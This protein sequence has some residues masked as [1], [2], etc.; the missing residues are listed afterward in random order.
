[1]SHLRPFELD[2]AFNGEEAREAGRGPFRRAVVR[3]PW[4]RSNPYG[5][6]DVVAG[7][8]R[9]VLAKIDMPN[10]PLPLE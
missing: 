6:H 7:P 8:P 5:A 9:R 1:V 4:G 10:R 3:E 2:P